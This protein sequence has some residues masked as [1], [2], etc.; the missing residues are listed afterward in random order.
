MWGEIFPLLFEL[1]WGMIFPS[2][3]DCSGG[4]HLIVADKYLGLNGLAWVLGL[5]GGPIPL[6]FVFCRGRLPG[7]VYLVFSKQILM[8]WAW[9]LAKSGHLH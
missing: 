9:A 4:P 2:L 6:L 8:L 5:I 3:L 1:L 7:F